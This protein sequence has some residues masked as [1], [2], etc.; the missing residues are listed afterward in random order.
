MRR[1]G[2]AAAFAVL[3]GLLLAPGAG[4]SFHLIKV[5]EVYLGSASAPESKYVE[6]QMYSSGQEF[7][8]GHSLRTYNASGGVIGT[9]TFAADVANGDNQSTILLATP[10]AEAEFGLAADAPLGSPA[11]LLPAG[12]AVCWEG[13]DCVSWGSFAGSLPSPAGAPAA[14][15]GV[16]AGMALGRTLARGCATALDSAD[17][18]NSG[19]ADFGI[20]APAPRP[21]SVAPVE[22][23]CGSGGSAG[24][25]G[26][27]GSYGAPGESGHG[28]PQTVLRRKPPKRT[29]DRTPSFRFGADE[30]KVRFQCKLDG[31]AYR[32][33]RSP[34]TTKRL[35]L[36]AHVFR[37]RAIDSGGHSDPSPASYR[38]RVVEKRG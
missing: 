8:K 20:V 29:A 1:F 13:L 25:G 24:G 18:T 3:L 32:A 31:A 5:R 10:A 19:A 12:G 34:F 15:A 7:V 28:T 11:G 27:S 26:G 14:T 37:V 23:S 22:A 6:L 9:S 30:A 2:L 16:P 21:N 17:D 33:C 35:S 4:A 36:G 38:F